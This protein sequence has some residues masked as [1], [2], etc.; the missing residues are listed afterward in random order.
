[1][2]TSLRLIV[3]ATILVSCVAGRVDRVAD[4]IDLREDRYDRRLDSGPGDRR[5][6]HW[7]KRE[8]VNDKFRGR[9]S[10]LH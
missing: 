3:P 9:S 7:A 4:R 10:L 5:E 8:S 2:K 1:M 6:D